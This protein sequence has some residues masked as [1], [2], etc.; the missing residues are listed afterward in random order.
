MSLSLATRRRRLLTVRDDIDAGGGACI[1]YPGI[2]AD[3]PQDPTAETP[4]AIVSLA[5]VSFDLHPTDASMSLVEAVGNAA[6]AGQVTWARFV[7][8]LGDPVYDCTASPPGGGGVLII[9]DGANPPTAVMFVGGE[10]TLNAT[11]TEP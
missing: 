1:L 4:I 8:G 11:F 9:T 10:V 6:V 3:N 2:I 5:P 7:N